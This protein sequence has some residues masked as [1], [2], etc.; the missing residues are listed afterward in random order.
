[1]PRMRLVEC[2]SMG[3]KAERDC[4]TYCLRHRHRL[5]GTAQTSQDSLNVGEALP[6]GHDGLMG[7]L[8]RHRLCLFRQF[9]CYD[10]SGDLGEGQEDI[11]DLPSVSN[12]SQRPIPISH[13]A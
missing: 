10:L 4:V 9:T 12:W 1:M 11:A 7:L 2:H 3:R 8:K 5:R 13:F 6:F